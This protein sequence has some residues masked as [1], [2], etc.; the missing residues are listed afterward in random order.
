MW[1]IAYESDGERLTPNEERNLLRAHLDRLGGDLVSSLGRMR[2][3]RGRP[4]TT[5]AEA[6]A[7]ADAW[8]S[9]DEFP[10][11]L[12]LDSRRGSVA[13]ALGLN[14]RTAD[15]RIRDARRRGLLE[16][17]ELPTIDNEW[18]RRERFEG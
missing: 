14:L 13:D 5:M 16:P 10:S 9:P 12:V 17:T 18:S 11:N 4:R 15:D 7:A 3:G 1:R 2:P 8:H 6:R